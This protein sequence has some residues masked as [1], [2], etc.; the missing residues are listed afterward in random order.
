MKHQFNDNSDKVVEQI[1]RVLANVCHHIHP[2]I[3]NRIVQSNN[4]FRDEFNSFC[5]NP[6]LTGFYFY[7]GSDCVFPGL[8]RPVGIEKI[9]KWKNNVCHADSTILNDNTY[10]RHIWSYL[11][12]GR[13]YSGGT[14]GFYSTSG[15]DAF[16]LAHIFSHKVDERILEPKAFKA[17]NPN[18]KPYA[19]FS[20]ASNVVLIPKW[21]P[22]PTDKSDLLKLV[23]YKRHLELYSKVSSLPGLSDFNEDL[24]PPWYS[25]IEWSDPELPID[26]EKKTDLLIIYRNKHLKQKYL[27]YQYGQT[28]NSGSCCTTLPK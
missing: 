24:L 18:F 21:L 17:Y 28:A 16:E 26:W 5:P 2:S 9:G 23:F 15:L 20:S 27:K 4:T 7:E 13:G 14:G 19:L 12:A 8:R 25:S 22:K 10:P 6:V 11:C 3:V 1:A